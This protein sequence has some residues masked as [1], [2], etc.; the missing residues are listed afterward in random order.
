[1]FT[2]CEISHLCVSPLVGILSQCLEHFLALRSVRLSHVLDD[3]LFLVLGH[4]DSLVQSHLVA[5]ST[6]LKDALWLRSWAS[7]RKT[8]VLP[9]VCM[10]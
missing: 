1:M 3:I 2:L 5:P 6:E 10:P 9:G 8:A 4:D 7:F